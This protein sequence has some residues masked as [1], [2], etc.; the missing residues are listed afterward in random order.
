[1]Y[2]TKKTTASHSPWKKNRKRWNIIKY[3]Q[4]SHTHV[5]KKH[6]THAIALYTQSKEP[7]MNS[8]E[9]HSHSKEPYIHSKEPYKHTQ[10]HHHAHTRPPTCGKRAYNKDREGRAGGRKGGGQADWRCSGGRRRRW[11]RWGHSHRGHKG[12]KLSERDGCVEI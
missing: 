8:K 3:A 6:H 1:M 4:K 11:H 5:A 2:D 10:A 7:Y 12:R 9:P